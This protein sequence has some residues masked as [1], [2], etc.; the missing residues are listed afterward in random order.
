M[1]FNY[2]VTGE[3]KLNMKNNKL[4]YRSIKKLIYGVFCYT[5]CRKVKIKA[6]KK[7]RDACLEC[8]IS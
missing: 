1:V 7:G 8:K 3:V 2:N 6:N 4:E 5:I